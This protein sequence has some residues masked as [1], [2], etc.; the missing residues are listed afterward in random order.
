MVLVAHSWRE[1]HFINYDGPAAELAAAFEAASGYPVVV[2]DDIAPTPGSLGTWVGRQQ[3][4]PILTIEYERGS[5]PSRC[6]QETRAAILAVI[7]PR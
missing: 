6:W 1:R 3:G 7:D 2:S 4:I 5:D